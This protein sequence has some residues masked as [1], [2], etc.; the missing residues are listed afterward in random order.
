MDPVFLCK[1]KKNKILLKS[2]LKMIRFINQNPYLEV[3][4]NHHRFFYTKELKAF[5]VKRMLSRNQQNHI[6][7]LIKL[8]LFDEYFF[9]IYPQSENEIDFLIYFEPYRY[10]YDFI[11]AFFKYNKG[12][13]I[14]PNSLP[15]FVKQI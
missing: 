8:S 10:K 13:F 11:Y 3:M 14:I 12:H 7:Y 2:K 5:F 9:L 15:D 1:Y 6:L 4:I